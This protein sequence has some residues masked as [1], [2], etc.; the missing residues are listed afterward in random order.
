M[1]NFKSRNERPTSRILYTI[2]NFGLFEWVSVL[3]AVLVLSAIAASA[4]EDLT[5][6]V[7]DNV[8]VKQKPT[9][10]VGSDKNIKTRYLIITDRE[11]FELQNNFFQGKFNNADLYYNLEEGKKYRF[12]VSGIKKSAFFNYRNILEA[13]KIE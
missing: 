5:V 8:I 10:I 2:S 9:Q 6:E 3:I 12:K 13:T 1:R 4:Y 7:V 11:T